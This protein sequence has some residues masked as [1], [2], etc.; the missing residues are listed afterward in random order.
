MMILITGGARSGK[1]RLAESMANDIACRNG[2]EVL[3]IAT[4]VATDPEMTLRIEQHK[5]A[6]PA[7]WK[8]HEGYRQL[9]NE[10]RSQSA[11]F[12]VIVLECITTMLTNLLF[13]HA[14]DADPEKLDYDAIESQ[15]APQIDDLLNACEASPSQ[16]IIVTN[17]LGCGIVPGYTLAR[18]F[19]D[20]AGRVNQRLAAQADEVHFVVSGIDMK[21]KG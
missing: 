3:Y 8:T 21:I 15:L 7:H 5:Q 6:R 11:D 12:P 20:I 2:G 10:I 1:S 17:E 19:L 9:G 16:I 18:R 4:S 13:D 14:G